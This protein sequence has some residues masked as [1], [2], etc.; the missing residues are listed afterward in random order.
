MPRTRPH[1]V[2]LC[3]SDEQP[4]ASSQPHTTAVAAPSRS[5]LVQRERRREDVRVGDL[6]CCSELLPSRRQEVVH[7]QAEE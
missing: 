2:P 5:R 3:E 7:L 6:G 4:A 1:S